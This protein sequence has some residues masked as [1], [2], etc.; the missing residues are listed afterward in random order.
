MSECG[1]RPQD[2]VSIRR[3]EPADLPRCVE[4]AM[5]VW[6]D[7]PAAMSREEMTRLMK[8]YVEDSKILSTWHE[9]AST[10]QEVVGVLFGFVEAGTG[11][12]D[13]IER[14]ALRTFTWLRFVAHR[15]A[16]IPTRLSVL[17]KSIAT[18]MKLA[19]SR[20]D[21]DAEVMLLLVRPDHRGKGIGRLLMS[22]F[23]LEARNRNARVVTVYTTEP[24]CNW[25]FYEICGFQMVG[26]FHD[27]LVSFVQGV[28]TKGLVF[29]I[30]L[31]VSAEAS[32]TS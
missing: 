16:S 12:K 28:E 1:G 31:E 14:A 9:V 13:R 5:D 4:I 25:R 17:R 6:P 21:T 3:Y 11:I 18:E 23:L 26:D 20:P 29:A 7:I 22:R 24:G 27:D 2:K 30:D 10:S 15:K 8:A 32:P 19:K